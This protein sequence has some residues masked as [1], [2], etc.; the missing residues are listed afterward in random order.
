MAYGTAFY[1]II[2]L[3]VEENAASVFMRRAIR[4]LLLYNSEVSEEKYTSQAIGT[5]FD[6]IS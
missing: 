6:N 2:I 1:A 4:I 5:L 3:Y